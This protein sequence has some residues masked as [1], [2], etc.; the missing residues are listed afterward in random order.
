LCI[1][2]EHFP[3]TGSTR[4]TEAEPLHPQHAEANSSEYEFCYALAVKHAATG[5]LSWRES[6]ALSSFYYVTHSNV[7]TFTGVVL[8]RRYILHFLKMR[9]LYL[10]DK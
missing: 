3:S 9:F 8:G 4:R 2:A 5:G 7:N 1:N 10:V 6:T